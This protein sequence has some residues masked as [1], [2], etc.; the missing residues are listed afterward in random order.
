MRLTLRRETFTD[1]S[2]TGRLLVD[3]VFFC[4]TLEDPDRR[5]ELH[6]DRKIPGE[7]AIP[8]GVYKLVVDWSPRF[9]QNMP[10]ILGVPGYDG[11]RMH[12]GNKPENTDGCPLVGDALLT[13]WISHSRATY[14]KLVSML[15]KAQGEGKEIT[16]EVT[17]PDDRPP[18]D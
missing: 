5:L 8:R 13:D 17:G 7:T 9:K 2:A 10:H 3:G 14:A 15:E 4:Y 12:W 1:R 6:Q 16:I 18:V 11:V